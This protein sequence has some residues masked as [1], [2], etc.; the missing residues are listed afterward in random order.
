MSYTTNESL[1]R[2]VNNIIT[3]AWLIKIKDKLKEELIKN[4][5]QDEIQKKAEEQLAKLVKAHGGVDGVLSHYNSLSKNASLRL[6]HNFAV[7][8]V[9]IND[10]N[11]IY[12]AY[13]GSEVDMSIEKAFEMN[14]KIYSDFNVILCRKKIELEQSDAYKELKLPVKR[15]CPDGKKTYLVDMNLQNWKRKSNS[16]NFSAVEKNLI[17]EMIKYLRKRANCTERAILEQVYHEF[18]PDI[19]GKIDLFTQLPPC[20]ECNI[21]IEEFR[22]PEIELN[23]Y[24]FSQLLNLGSGR[25]KT[26]G[27]SEY[28][29]AVLED[30]DEKLDD[31][32]DRLK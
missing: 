11:K 26:P 2:L 20:Q 12:F 22:N 17:D 14:K 28:A 16:G 4:G 8:N 18:A 21:L 30:I 19:K 24:D 7:A 9:N 13:S 31:I 27:F 6:K 5:E 10:E 32:K 1:N 3:D 23:V 15:R 25:E 29:K